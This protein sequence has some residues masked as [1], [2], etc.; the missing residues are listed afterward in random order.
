MFRGS[1][2][3]QGIR[4]L[5][6]VFSGCG[7]GARLEAEAVVSGF[8][9]VAAVGEAVEQ[10]CGHLGIAEDRG[11]P[12]PLHRCYA[13]ITSRQLFSLPWSCAARSTMRSC[14]V[15]AAV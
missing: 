15:P 13:L 12:S 14:Q 2:L 7:V 8:K 9:D 5:L 10:G 4:F 11:P 6:P 1:V 3:S